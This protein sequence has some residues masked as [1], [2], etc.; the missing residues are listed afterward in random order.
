ME[1]TVVDVVD[2]ANQTELFGLALRE[3]RFKYVIL[4]HATGHSF[5]GRRTCML[6]GLGRDIDPEGLSES[7]FAGPLPVEK[8]D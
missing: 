1:E 7:M 5:H 8:E 4:C 2:L 6:C 3:M